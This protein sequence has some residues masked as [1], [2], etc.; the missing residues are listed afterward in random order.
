MKWTIL[1][2][3]HSMWG[4][5]RATVAHCIS[6]LIMKLQGRPLFSSLSSC[7]AWWDCSQATSWLS[8]QCG[9]EHCLVLMYSK[10]LNEFFTEK[11]Y[12]QLKTALLTMTPLPPCSGRDAFIIVFLTR[13]LKTPLCIII[14]QFK[15][16]FITPQL[17]S[18]CRTAGPAFSDQQ[19]QNESEGL[20]DIIFFY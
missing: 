8:L 19:P 11:Y 12:Q 20:V 10:A 7:Q 1:V 9:K 16:W 5:P 14:M 3:Y 4:R 17:V 6:S 2:E 13:S 15:S 18:S